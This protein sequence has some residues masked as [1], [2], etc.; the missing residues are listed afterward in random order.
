MNDHAVPDELAPE[1]VAVTT[2]QA[3][4]DLVGAVI[5]QMVKRDATPGVRSLFLLAGLAAEH[6][7]GLSRTFPEGRPDWRLAIDP[8]IGEGVLSTLPPEHLSDLPAVRIRNTAA[9][10]AVLFAVPD[11]DRGAVGA[12]LG[13]VATID[14]DAIEAVTDIWTDVIVEAR[15]APLSHEKKRYLRNMLEG[16]RQAGVVKHLDQFAEF[17][18]MFAADRSEPPDAILTRTPPVLHLPRNCYARPPRCVDK[19]VAGPSEFRAMFRNAEGE[20][21]GIPYLRDRNEARLDHE[22]IRGRLDEIEEEA[23]VGDTT[24]A[25]PPETLDAVRTL[26]DDRLDLRHGEWQDSQRAFC[27]VFDFGRFGKRVFGARKAKVTET[28]AERTRRHLLDEFSSGFDEAAADALRRVEEDPGDDA[29][30]EAFFDEHRDAIEH[31][32]KLAGEWRKRLYPSTVSDEQDLLRALLSGVRTALIKNAQEGRLGIAEGTRIVVGARNAH[33]LSAWKNLDRRVLQLFRLEMQLLVGV[34]GSV[35]DFDLGLWLAGG[36]LDGAKERTGKESRTVELEISLKAED[37]RREG[38][39]IRVAWRPSPGPGSIVL[40]LPEDIEALKQGCE[41]DGIRLRREEIT[42]KGHGD[43]AAIDLDDMASFVDVAQSDHGRTADPTGGDHRPECFTVI[44]EGLARIRDAGQIEADDAQGLA[45][46]VARF[47]TRFTE[48]IQLVSDRPEEALV[49]AVVPEA[50][51]AFGEMCRVARIV[52][53]DDAEARRSVMA[54]I[55]EL[56]IA[57][58]ATAV[59]AAIVPAWHP[60]RLLERRAKALAVADLVADVSD[61]RTA[62]PEGF[63][64][65]CRDLMEVVGQ[66]HFPEVVSVGRRDYATIDDRSGYGLA[67]PVEARRA[68]TQALEASAKGACREFMAVADRYLEMSPHEEANFGAAIYASK[69]VELPG[70][71]AEA[72]EDRMARRPDLRCGLLITHDDA[73]RMRRTYS[74]Q[75]A[76]LQGRG[77][78]RGD[79]SFLSRLRVGVRKGGAGRRGGHPDIDLVLLHDVVFHRG[80]VDWRSERETSEILAEDIDIHA[81]M[82][83]RRRLSS[84]DRS[85]EAALMSERPP[86]AAA[87]FA[88]L[89]HDV[90]ETNRN[91]RSGRRAVPVRRVR[92]D[93]GGGTA[94]ALIDA[95]HDLATWVVTYDRL[96]TRAMLSDLGIKVIRDVP[97]AGGTHRLLVSAREPSAGLKRLVR[98]VLAP[99]ARLGGALLQDE[100]T[101]VAVGSVVRACGQKI[102]D[103]GRSRNTAREIVGLAAAIAA[104]EAQVTHGLPKPVWFSLDDTKALFGL[105]GEIADAL[106][107][108]VEDGPSE[109][110]C[111]LSVVEAKCTGREDAASACSKSLHQTAVTLRA[112]RE[113]FVDADDPLARRGWGVELARLLATKPEFDASFG[114]P[115]E[116]ADFQDALVSGNVV[117]EVTGRSVVVAHDDEEDAGPIAAEVAETEDGIVQHR[118]GRNGLARLMAFAAGRGE[119]PRFQVDGEPRSVMVDGHA[120]DNTESKCTLGR[121]NLG[122]G[123]VGTSDRY[124]DHGATA[125]RDAVGHGVGG[126]EAQLITEGDQAILSGSGRA[127]HPGQSLT[128]MPSAFPPGVCAVLTRLAA[129]T[130]VDAE[131]EA[132]MGEADRIAGK[133]QAALVDFGMRA[134]PAGDP[135][136]ATPNGFIVRF[137]GHS[138]LTVKKVDARRSELKTT[139]GLQV[140]DIREGLGWVGIFVARA[141]RRIV[142]LPRVWLSSAWPKGCPGEQSSLL[143]GEREDTGEPLWLNLGGAHGGN[144]THAPHTLIAGETGSGKGVLTQ[145]ILLQLTAMNSPRRLRVHLVDP[146][147]GV[148]FAWIKDAPHLGGGIVSSPEGASTLFEELVAEMER[149]YE[150]LAAEGVQH[151]GQFNARVPED[152]RLPRLV[153]IH[154]EMA[155]WMAGVEGYKDMIQRTALRLAAKGRASGV[156]LVMITQRAAQDAIPVGIRDNLG[157]RLC[158]KVQSEAGSRLALGRPGADRLLGRGHLAAALGGERPEDGEYFLVQ[159]PF[160]DLDDL[161]DLGRAVAE[162]WS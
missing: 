155:D 29:A 68:D 112:F 143:L 144:E 60:L 114:S 103:G 14:R 135:V 40:A 75:N 151:L 9:S 121:A 120:R 160:A 30:A 77:S 26:L 28:L 13:P 61:G 96:A 142:S 93:E 8:R 71:V 84:V 76:R 70:L 92:W 34:L 157:N 2:R 49:G 79:G 131:R 149:R 59:E 106:A 152:R 66:W 35:I 107:V 27:E 36:A 139:Y 25:M 99:V 134:A 5:W 98:D 125:G 137:R 127:A 110:R 39:L 130:G 101:D 90:H 109:R 72:L 38:D 15:G 51:H 140:A 56:A 74:L 138:S 54:P 147:A 116:R 45:K 11:V 1:P 43:D 102:L 111:R 85:V 37:D 153:A 136:T 3:R 88:D 57:R 73:A 12:S 141:K 21:R 80:E 117:F 94:G 48:A 146:K 86:R 113:R 119:A 58:S 145:N 16:L 65:L 78:L 159:V 105:G 17:A 115:K 63:D 91:L 52:L 67:V 118:L 156:H 83:P 87:Q 31:D 162:A 64:R 132:D 108:V 18:A 6:L 4:S 122:V 150:L 95:A 161:I 44:Y 129:Q 154:D 104:V 22:A 47:R 82:L 148:D 41:A 7:A 53:G 133:L 23:K 42:P 33:K 24:G 46:A 126:G 20:L 19:A 62:S 55:C 97:V 124:E 10:G 50:A 128:P 123:D 89:C 32:R 69:S 100:M 158:L 81:L